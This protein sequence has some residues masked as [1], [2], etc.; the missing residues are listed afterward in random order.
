MRRL[1]VFLLVLAVLVFGA[2]HW[3]RGIPDES[4]SGAFDPKV[5]DPATF[6]IFRPFTREIALLG[7]VFTAGELLGILIALAGITAGFM[8]ENGSSRRRRHA[9]GKREA[10]HR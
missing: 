3:G 2:G 8:P 10:D 1:A 5:F 6:D 4:G 9:G 7:F